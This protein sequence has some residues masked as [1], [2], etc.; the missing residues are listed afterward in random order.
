LHFRL[1][2]SVAE[3]GC[4]K[5]RAA[6]RLC[7]EFFGADLGAAILDRHREAAFADAVLTAGELTGLERATRRALAAPDYFDDLQATVTD[8][9]M[10]AREILDSSPTP[11]RPGNLAAAGRLAI[12]HS[13]CPELN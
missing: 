1:L 8:A 2:R 3:I 5:H 9:S 12:T 7:Q 10:Q 11:P 13:K 4:N 6:G